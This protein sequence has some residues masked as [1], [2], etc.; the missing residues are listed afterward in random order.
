MCQVNVI[1]ELGRKFAFQR[2]PVVLLAA[3]EETA[4]NRA[5]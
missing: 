2:M 3:K 5:N 4:A 1:D